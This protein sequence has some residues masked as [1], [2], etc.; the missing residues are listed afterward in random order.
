[1]TINDLFN[2]W[3]QDPEYQ[4]EERKQ[5]VFLDLGI[6]FYRARKKL[7]LSQTRL[8]KLAETAQPNISRIEGGEGNPT[9]SFI[10][11]LAKT[12]NKKVVIQLVD[13]EYS[14]SDFVTQDIRIQSKPETLEQ[15]LFV[16]YTVNIAP[17]PVTKFFEEVSP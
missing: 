9:L 2:D 12:L 3:E 11:K 8:A 5:G 6:A 14:A 13:F 17:Q 7:G 1:M 4:E 16:N 10:I 15:S